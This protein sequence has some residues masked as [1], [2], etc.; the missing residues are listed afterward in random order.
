MT[1]YLEPG[2]TIG[3]IGAG[4]LG[5]MMAQS[6]QK[7]GYQVATYDPNPK[8]CAFPVSNWH[9][10]GSFDDAEALLKFAQKVDVLTYEFENINASIL[11]TLEQQVNFPQKTY[12]LLKSQDR[13]KEKH[14][15]NEIG[16]PTTAYWAISTWDELKKALET[17]GFPVI[18]KTTRLGYDGKGQ[19]KF[20]SLDEVEQNRVVVEQML[21]NFCVLEA[22]CPFIAELSV[23]AARDVSGKINVFPLSE[24][25]HQEGILFTSTAPAQVDSAIEKKIKLY[26]NKI[27]YEGRL[28]GVMGIEFFLMSDGSLVVNELAPR[29]HN[30]GHYTIEACNVSQFDQHIL[31]IVGRKLAPIT[32]LKPALMI[33]LLGQDLSLVSKIGEDY[34]EANIHLYQ[35]GEGSHNR[36]MGHLT[37]LLDDSDKYESLIDLISHQRKLDTT[38]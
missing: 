17:S 31:A 21:T 9:H 18:L 5:K 29:P 14:W 19:I 7:Y 8:A 10:V 12:L 23:I 28:V 22:Y 37:L 30:T 4:Q 6:A 1:N 20:N 13:I 15:L 26:A 38:H 34:P 33:N 35:K 25:V 11:A 3:I 32:Q 36:K 27:A 2:A 16:V 24:N